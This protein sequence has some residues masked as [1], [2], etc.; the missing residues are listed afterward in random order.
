MNEFRIELPWPP[1]VNTYWRHA[2]GRHYISAK[3]A[4]YRKDIIQ[5]IQQQHLDINTT[6]RLKI[7]IT[8]NQPDKRRRD[9]DNL[10]KAVFDSLVHAGFM[11]DDEQIDDFR[12]RRGVQVPGGSLEI[13]ITEL[14]V[15]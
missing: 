5:I 8:A 10:Q 11:A 6:A 4:K 13:I 15:A 3:G 1:T 2:R 9:L 14:E 7:S 12:V